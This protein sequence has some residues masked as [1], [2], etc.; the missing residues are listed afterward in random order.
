MMDQFVVGAHLPSA[1][2]NSFV[3]LIASPLGWGKEEVVLSK[4]GQG[5]ARVLCCCVSAAH[6]ICKHLLCG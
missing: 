3:G 1:T 4:C 6:Q 5:C 2:G